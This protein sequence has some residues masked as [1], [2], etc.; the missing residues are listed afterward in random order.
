MDPTGPTQEAADE[1][2]PFSYEGKSLLPRLAA[3]AEEVQHQIPSLVGLS[4]SLVDMGVTFTFVASERRIA[5]LDAMQHADHGPCVDAV[6]AVDAREVVAFTSAEHGAGE[7]RWRLFVRASQAH[8]VATTLSLLL[9]RDGAVLGSFNLYAAWEH[10]FDAHHDELAQVLGAWAGGAV[11]DADLSFSSRDVV[12]RAPAILR[13]ATRIL[14]A[15][16]L[17]VKLR[18]I[19][20]D[21]AERRLRDTAVLAG[22]PL[23]AVVDT[24]ID[25]LGAD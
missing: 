15:R 4:L 10:A 9:V 3:F 21:E 7:D 22:I 20:K 17:L 16:A 8:G 19:E 25:V 18:G 1:H 2:G 6:D 12:A 5:V 14:V 13:G 23:D 24:V 11:T